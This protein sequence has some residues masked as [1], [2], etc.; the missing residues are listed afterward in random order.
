MVKLC[1]SITDLIVN[2]PFDYL[3]GPF[4]STFSTTEQSN[5]TN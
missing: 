3:S 2:K 4:T 5:G 1:I